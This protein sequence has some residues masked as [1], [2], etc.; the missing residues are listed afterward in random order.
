MSSNFMAS[1][2]LSKKQYLTARKKHP[3]ELQPFGSLVRKRRHQREAIRV[4]KIIAKG[5]IR[6]RSAD[7]KIH[8][9]GFD[10]VEGI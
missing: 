8:T 6:V 2:V 9:P 1:L 4:E 5:G 3:G 7:G 10:S